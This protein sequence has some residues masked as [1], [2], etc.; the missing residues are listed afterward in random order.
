MAVI[1]RKAT[2]DDLVRLPEIEV[3]AGEAFRAIGMGVIA[4]HDPPGVVELAPYQR[5]GR[6]WVA[7]DDGGQGVVVGYIIVDM[8]DEAT[9]IEQVSVDPVASGH[10]IGRRLI[11][12]VEGWAADD[13]RPAVT[14]TTFIDVAWNGPYYRRL[15]YREIAVGEL[16]PG[17][18]AIRAAEADLGLDRWPRMAMIKPL[19]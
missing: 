5:A 2:P 11:E 6:C 7:V 16:S 4:D 13:G 10:G 12:L 19:T 9:H 17:L 15:G 14:L 18:A 1:L 3:R 8:V